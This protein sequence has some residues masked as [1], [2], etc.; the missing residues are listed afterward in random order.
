MNFY[1]SSLEGLKQVLHFSGETRYENYIDECIHD[2]ANSQSTAKLLAA[3]GKGGIFAE[4]TFPLSDFATEEEQ[5]WCTQ[6]FGGLVAMTVQ[7]ARFHQNNRPIS[8]DYMRRNFGIPSDVISGYKCTSCGTKEINQ[9]Q[10]DRYITPKVVSGTIIDGLEKE[11]LSERIEALLSLRSEGLK[12]ARAEAIA[13]ALNSNVSV[14]DDRKPLTICKHC[15][16]RAIDKCRF[17]RHT[18]QPS[19]VALSR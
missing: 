3:F 12:A 8:I 15:G 11:D 9:A 14:A 5:F 16:S 1:A 10:I 19:F 7:L 4:F 6:L 18:K 17:L 2:W 13:R